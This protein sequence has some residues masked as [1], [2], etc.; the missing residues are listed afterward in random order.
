MN[1][2]AD[3]IE[4]EI[5]RMSS[6]SH[7]V[8]KIVQVVNDPSSSARDLVR[9]IQID[10][11]LTAKVLRIV[12]S[13]F[14]SVQQEVTS[15]NKAVIMV[16]MNTVKNLALSTAVLNAFNFDENQSG[17][18]HEGFW[19]YSVGTAVLSK[20]LAQRGQLSGPES[21]DLFIVGLLHVIGKA[22]LLQFYPS[23]YRNIVEISQKEELPTNTLEKKF[24]GVTHME[25][26]TILARNWKLPEVVRD[27][28]ENYIQPDH[29]EFTTT[30]YL[31][32]SSNAIKVNR[33]GFAGDYQAH[34]ENDEIL[35]SI[36]I[37]PLVLDDII[38][39]QLNGD[40]EK[41]NAFVKSK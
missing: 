9:V 22:F 24:F 39:N 35:R 37:D 2:K 34:L 28:I 26:G 16:G 25:V 20:T 11:V 1:L 32:I 5:Q 7:T 31:S 14:Y 17:L 27:G 23:Q 41:A 8:P 21:E 4:H 13:A 3:Q 40:L 38:S 33:I 15:L 18:T 10:P 6:L 30:K 12:N 36:C 19:M 29:S